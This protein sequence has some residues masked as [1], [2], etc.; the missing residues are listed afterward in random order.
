M[1]PS[2]Y[3]TPDLVC[4]QRQPDLGVI[5]RRCRMRQD[6]EAGHT[7]LSDLVLRSVSKERIDLGSGHK[8]LPPAAVG[9]A[10]AKPLDEANDKN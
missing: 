4:R 10:G 8:P 9:R 5:R 7:V 1:G 2:A 6:R 3:R